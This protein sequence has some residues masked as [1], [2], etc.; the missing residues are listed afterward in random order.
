[1]ANARVMAATLQVRG[2][3]IVSGGTDNHLMLIDLSTK[4]LYRQ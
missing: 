1:L 3:K 4:A 2:Y